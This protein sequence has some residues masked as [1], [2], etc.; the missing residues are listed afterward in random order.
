M[1]SPTK[2][3]DMPREMWD[4]DG[5]DDP[6][7]AVYSDSKKLPEPDTFPV[8]AMPRGTWQLINEASAAIGC[9]PEFVGLPMLAA[10]GSAIG[11]SRVLKLK[12]GWEEGA[13]VYAAVVGAPGEKKTP[14]HKVAIAPATKHQASL[15]NA[16]RVAEDEYKRLARAYE[17]EKRDAAK[18]G[19]PA[20]PPP[21]P[22]VMGRSVVEDTTV[23]AL[24]VVVEGT[25]RGVMV[26]RDEIA[27]WVRS[28][29]PVQGGWQGR[30]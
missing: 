25:P 10:L 21:Q 26:V 11:N 13:A 16:Y 29:E 9:P 30:R 1:S 18:T 22:P 15:R 28:M 7:Y 6:V 12:D 19:E 24:A 8:G 27:G 14:A 4:E 20:P 2:P 3:K 23:E 17:V 5:E